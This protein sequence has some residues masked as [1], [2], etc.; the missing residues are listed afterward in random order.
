M[1]LSQ[2]QAKEREEKISYWQPHMDA[3]QA[4]S[5]SA[6]AYCRKHGISI[7]RFKYWQYRLVPSKKE[8]FIF[9]GN[10]FT[11]VQFSNRNLIYPLSIEILV[12]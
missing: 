7:H 1:K 10:L 8:G 5:I 6:T 9:N 11:E 3:W 4:E 12:I 2:R